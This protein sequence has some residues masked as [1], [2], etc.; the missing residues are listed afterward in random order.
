MKSGLTEDK[1]IEYSSKN[2]CIT[3][4]GLPGFTPHFGQ[5]VVYVELGDCCQ[6]HL[7]EI[8]QA[9]SKTLEEDLLF[10]FHTTTDLSRKLTDIFV[11][12][13][14]RILFLKLFWL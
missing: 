9:S 2:V 5:I 13:Q 6:A 3:G 14:P 8:Y 11:S 4:S 12:D 10:D 1:L 7:E